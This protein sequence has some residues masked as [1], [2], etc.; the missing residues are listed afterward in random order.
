MIAL[1]ID[2][3][4]E[5]IQYSISKTDTTVA[6]GDFYQR[7]AFLPLEGGMITGRGIQKWFRCDYSSSNLRSHRSRRVPATDDAMLALFRSIAQEPILMGLLLLW[8]VV[9]VAGIA[10]LS[11]RLEKHVS[12]ST[13]IIPD[14]RFM[15]YSKPQLYQEFYHV[16]GRSG[17][18]IYSA[19][20][21][22]DM[23]V[24]IPAY[25]L[26]LATTWVHIARRT[27]DKVQSTQRRSGY[28]NADRG[29]FIVLPIALF[30]YF[31]TLVQRHGCTLLASS[32]QELS[33]LLV[34]LASVSV[35]IKWSL[36]F[37]YFV[38]ILDRLCKGFSGS[39][40][41]NHRAELPLWM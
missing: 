1:E 18:N 37:L 10:V 34:R 11:H 6:P 9:A 30:D 17:C 27:Y 13:I 3:N 31:E 16:V 32:D 24:L 12:P 35:S 23:L 7:G 15:G 33:V 14:L 25:T 20:A 29:A 39:T 2:T 41:R 28:W 22:W 19:L 36:L 5:D 26:A 8:L 38:S 40:K 21:F 4:L